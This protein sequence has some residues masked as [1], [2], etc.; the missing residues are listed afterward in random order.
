[1]K[2][3][4]AW[5]SYSV[6]RVL[7]FA[8]PLAVLLT[9]QFEWW[10]ATGLAALIGVS[11]SY[12]LLRKPRE[13]VALDLYQARHPEKDVIH[14]DA[15]SEDASLDRAEAAAASESSRVQASESPKASERERQAE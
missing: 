8:V 2:A 6:L 1:M 11:L 3:V 5:L 13:K 9:L 7:L 10:L 15:A 12:I 14:P 4:P